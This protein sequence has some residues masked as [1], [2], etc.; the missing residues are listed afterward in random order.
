MCLPKAPITT[1]LWRTHFFKELFD[2]NDIRYKL[3]EWDGE[4]GREGFLRYKK[5]KFKPNLIGDIVYMRSAEMLLIQAESFARE[6]KT[7]EAISALNKLR[8]ARNA[9]L[10]TTTQNKDL[11]SEILI[12]RRKELWGEGFALSDIIRNQKSVERKAYIDNQ[13]SPIKVT[14]TTPTGA[15]KIVN[16]QGHRVIKFPDGTNFTANSRYYLFA[17]PQ[18]EGQQNPNL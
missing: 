17:I 11:L 4:T 12:E 3:F 1:A 5:F 8:S 15:T 16:G 18:E 14:V 13:G 6:G 2:Q 9:T 10:Y 7:D